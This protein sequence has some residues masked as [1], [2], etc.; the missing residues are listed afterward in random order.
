MNP[1]SRAG[2]RASAFFVKEAA[3]ALGQ[4]RLILS[5]IV[6][7]FLLLLLFGVGFTG[8]R[9]PYKTI[10]VVPDRPGIPTSVDAYR[11]FFLWSLRLV[12][13]TTSVDDALAR[14][15]DRRADVVVVAPSHPLDDLAH[16]RPATFRVYYNNL[17]PIDRGRINGLAFGHTRELN[18]M[19]VAAMLDSVMQ[20]AGVQTHSTPAIQELRTR[21]LAGDSQGALGEIDRLL[22]AVTILRLSGQGAYGVA[23]ETAATTAE[24]IERF[25][26]LLRALR[27]D[28]APGAGLTAAQEAELAE[29]TQTAALLPDVVEAA[30]RVSPQRL[31]APVDYDLTDIAPSAVSYV[32]FYTPVV[33]VLLLQHVAITLAALSV[34]RE[35]TRG[36]IELFRVAPV[37]LVEVMTGKALSFGAILAGLAAVLLLLVVFVLGVPMLGN[38]LLAALVVALLIAAALAIGFIIAA[39]STT[40]SQAVQL[41]MLVLLFST[42]FGGL[43][44]PLANL[45]MPVRVIAYAAPVTH[46][47]DALRDI[48]LRGDAFPVWPAVA[49]ALMVLMLTPA[50]YLLMRR[51]LRLC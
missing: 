36:T 20:A 25:E 43:L 48:M 18:A 35:R 14:L 10:L 6:G 39:I 42:L 30:A 45:D 29:L 12:D 41:A 9:A 46:A 27:A 8:S 1:L 34:V 15:R 3:V 51:S 47:G 24:P 37:R 32:S 31:A 11:G 7:P 4:R 33:L 40:E 44:L 5:V 17:D 23:A 19:I 16:D 26:T 28:V 13:V 2:R 50:A 49:L 38:V 21:L 22:A